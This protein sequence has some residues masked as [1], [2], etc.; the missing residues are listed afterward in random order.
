MNGNQLFQ[1]WIVAYQNWRPQ[2]WTDVP[3]GAVA[4]EPAVPSLMPAREAIEFLHGFNRTML[5]QPRNLWA[6]PVP[7]AV[8]YECRVVAGGIIQQSDSEPFD[9]LLAEGSGSPFDR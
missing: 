8:R 9:A 5:R 7:V 1:V 6:L 2:N 4:I 3:P